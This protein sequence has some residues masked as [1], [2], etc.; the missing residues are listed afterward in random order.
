MLRFIAVC[1]AV[2][3]L[4]LV[5]GC[6]SNY[7]N[8]PSSPL[9]V[10]TEAKLT[11]DILV[12]EEIQAVATVHR[13][14]L[15]FSW[16]PNTFAEGVNYGSNLPETSISSSIFGDTIAEA[17]AAAAYK[18]CNSCKADFIICPRYYTT[19]DNY[20][21]YRKSKVRVFGYRG[22]LK[23]IEKVESEDESEADTEGKTKTIYSV[24]I[25]TPIQIAEPIKVALP[26][27]KSGSKRGGQLKK[28]AAPVKVVGD[29]IQVGNPVQMASPVQAEQNVKLDFLDDQEVST[30]VTARVDASTK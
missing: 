13:L 8:Q 22:V 3:S 9:T 24:E 12:G 10:I 27:T 1:S 30:P 14:L 20:F 19:T 6:R 23:G 15:F 18:A 29:P 2:V 21:F 17:K 28:L 7:L 25:T 26:E 11:P 4:A 5:T 16:G